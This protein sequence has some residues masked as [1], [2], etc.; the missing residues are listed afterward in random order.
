MSCN[1]KTKSKIQT[2]R[3]KLSKSGKT[4]KSRRGR[5]MRGGSQASDLVNKAANSPAVIDDFVVSPRVRDGPNADNLMHQM[6]GSESSGSVMSLLADN[7][8]TQSPPEGYNVKG[9][10]NSLKLYETTGGSRK[11]KRHGSKKNGS[12][13]RGNKHSNK[14]KKGKNSKNNKI[15]NKNLQKSNEYNNSKYKNMIKGGGSDFS[16]TFYSQG[17]INNM[18]SKD[19][20][21]LFNPPNLGSAGSGAKMGALEGAGVNITGSPLV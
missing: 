15:Y 10:I 5:K 7:A 21:T 19:Y 4:H 16:Q 20:P 17:P 9:N 18:S 12:K 2:K 14:N 1:R 6:G 8:K 13:R 3:S 11:S